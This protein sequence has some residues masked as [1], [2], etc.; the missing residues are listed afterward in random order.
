MS[1]LVFY[2]KPGCAGNRQQQ[3]L[4][5]SLGYRLEIRDLLSEPW[6]VESLQLFL[7]GKTVPEW[8]NMN[9]PKV[10][11][12]EIDV[13]ALEEPEA[14]ALLLAEPLLICRPLLQCGELRQSGFSA[15][16]VLDVLQVSLRPEQDLLSCPEAGTGAVCG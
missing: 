8:F 2:E 7:V 5:R 1:D 12:G 16:P 13:Q 9:A 14:L 3:A 4:L 15:G 11:L 6:T 10:K